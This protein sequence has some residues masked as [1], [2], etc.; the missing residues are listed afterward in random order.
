MNIKKALIT[1][2]GRN[3]RT[4]PLQ[5]LVGQDGVSRTALGVV[6]EEALSA[7]LDEIAVVIHPGDQAAY[8]EAAGSHGRRLRFIEQTEPRG[9]GHA[10]ACARTFT[11][12]EPFLL[13]VGDHVY[14]SATAAS[15][16]RQLV[17][18]AAAERSAVSAVQATHESKLPYFGAIGAGA[19]DAS[20]GP[21]CGDSDADGIPNIAERI[22]GYFER[23]SGRPDA[24]KKGI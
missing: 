8:T 16:A 2:A 15:C 1:A 24:G 10:V 19:F 5:T 23:G 21:N 17:E 11:G 14:V 12:D 13:L 22:R 9:F 3:Q 6:I 18:V 20:A 4:L 7:G